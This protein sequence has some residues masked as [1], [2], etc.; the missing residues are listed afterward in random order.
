[1]RPI[2]PDAIAHD[3][4]KSAFNTYRLGAL[5][6]G[7]ENDEPGTVAALEQHSLTRASVRQSSLR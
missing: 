6:K 2:N 3:L 7:L 5:L 4:I 1:M